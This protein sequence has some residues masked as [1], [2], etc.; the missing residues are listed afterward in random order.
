[1][2]NRAWN[3]EQKYWSVPKE[4]AVLKKLQQLFGESLWV[5]NEIEWS[6]SS[7]EPFKQ[8]SNSAKKKPSLLQRLNAAQQTALVRL[9]EEL[10]LERKAY[11][12]VKAYRARMEVNNR[13]TN[14]YFFLTLR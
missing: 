11:N 6:T 3:K 4:E 10:R 14:G 7:I 12:T 8:P 9:E 5:A 1:L 2:P 13:S